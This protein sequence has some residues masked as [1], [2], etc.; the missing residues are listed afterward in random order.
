MP[1][2]RRCAL[3]SD[4]YTWNFLRAQRDIMRP[5]TAAASHRKHISMRTET[6]SCTTT[7]AISRRPIDYNAHK[8]AAFCHG[9]TSRSQPTRKKTWISIMINKQVHA[10]KHRCVLALRAH[11][12]LTP[13]ATQH[14]HATRLLRSHAARKETCSCEQTVVISRRPQY[15]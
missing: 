12:D 11:L 14:L 1:P 13:C 6:C 8:N 3:T 2:L 9:G 10:I 5:R 7:A 15:K 4:P